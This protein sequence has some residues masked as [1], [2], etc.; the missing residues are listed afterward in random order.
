VSIRLDTDCWPFQ[1]RE[2][3]AIPFASMSDV[4]AREGGESEARL[5]NLGELLTINL[6]TLVDA[7]SIA[8]LEVLDELTDLF[9]PPSLKC[10][11]FRKDLIPDNG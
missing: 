10:M 1:R 3:E 4:L 8:F 11:P 5:H 7:W 2:N 6:M 9:S